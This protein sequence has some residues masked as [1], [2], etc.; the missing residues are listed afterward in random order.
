MRVVY[1]T[2]AM[3]LLVVLL[4]KWTVLQAQTSTLLNELK[5]VAPG[6]DSTEKAARIVKSLKE[7]QDLSLT[8][9][10]ESMR[11]ATPL[12]RNWLSGVANNL[13][14]KQQAQS[15]DALMKFLQD[16][17]QDGEARYKA[18]IW[19]TENSPEQRSLLLSKMLEDPSPEIRYAA[20]E[21]SLGSA[22]EPESL[23]RLLNVARHPDQVV[24][25]IKKLEEAGSIVDQA[26]HFGFVGTWNLIGPF[27]H[28]G[29]KNFNK[30]FPIETD[31]VQGKIA[32]SYEGKKQAVKWQEYTSK[33]KD[34]N[35]DLAVIFA[36]EKGCIVYGTT[37]FNSPI[38]G[39]AE[40]R[41]GCINGHKIWLN[42]KLVMSNEVYH[43]STQI[44]QYIEPIELKKGTNRILIKVC[45]NEQTEA[46]A[47]RYQF[48]LR[49]TD[50]TGK[51]I[52]QPN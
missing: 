6:D 29:T 12:G 51:A 22:K 28:V 46:W 13:Y 37:E 17:T 27:D 39:P 19:L 45:Q 43:S 30:S 15:G 7:S 44:D 3:S 2:L 4:P 5:Q 38:E 42:G 48:M 33:E 14:R 9:V 32:E 18:F 47:Q 1:Q 10:L 41:L 52:Q 49:I 31:W 16:T 20:I 26:K 40:I 8:A 35:I 21:N 24:G 11:G 23:Q 50:S 34:G 36:N 25:L